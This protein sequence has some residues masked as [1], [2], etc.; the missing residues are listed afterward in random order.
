MR[1]EY[2]SFRR[3]GRSQIRA[4]RAVARFEGGPLAHLL[5]LLLRL[6][7]L[8]EQ[9]GLDAVEQALEPAH[10]L[11]LRDAELG[12]A[13]RVARE[14]QR[15]V[16]ELLAEVVGEDALELVYRAFVDLLE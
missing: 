10:Q 11:G 2:S 16:V 15:H 6:H 3:L 9:R 1:G 7:L 14:R 4:G 12:V 5:E 13:R 8:R